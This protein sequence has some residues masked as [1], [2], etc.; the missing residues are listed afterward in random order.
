MALSP[1]T[2]IE[3]LRV[4]TELYRKMTPQEKLR[5]VFSAYETGKTLAIAG[6]RR[7]HPEASDSEIWHLWAKAHLGEALY[8]QVYGDSGDE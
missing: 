3:S 8:R 7:L 4:L 1:D 5:Q 2:T 6:I